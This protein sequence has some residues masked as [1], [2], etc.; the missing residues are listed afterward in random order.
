MEGNRT[1]SLIVF[2]VLNKI[3]IYKYIVS[4]LFIM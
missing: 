3:T 2:K 4:E 1:K